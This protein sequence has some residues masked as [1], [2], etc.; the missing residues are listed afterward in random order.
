VNERRPLDRRPVFVTGG[1]GFIGQHLLVALRERGISAR[2]LARSDAAAA[3]VSRAGADVVRGDL[4]DLA[5]LT[6]GMRGCQAVVHLA[7]LVR[8]DGSRD[9]FQRDVIDG[10]S[11][12]LAA[13]RTAGVGRFVHMSTEAVLAAGKALDTD[14]REPYPRHTVGL[15]SWSKQEAEKRVLAAASNDFHTVAVRPTFVWGR[16]DTVLLPQISAAV[17]ANRFA[18]VGGGRARKSTSHV[19][20][21]VEGTLRALEYGAN[22]EAYFINDAEVRVL[23]DFLTSLLATQGIDI[24]AGDIPLPLAYGA[25]KATEAAWR[26]TGRRGTPALSVAALNLV[27]MDWVFSC[28]KAQRDLGYAPVV[29]VAQGM[30]ELRGTS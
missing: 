25:A 10:T 21:V 26:L 18:W 24:H 19:G 5:S 12:V 29:S 15:Y 14:E 4:S 13:A 1:S 8:D 27:F 30:A 9:D 11:D 2:A 7:A 22:A 6:N 28:E 16:G 23:R 3:A 17:T 20:N